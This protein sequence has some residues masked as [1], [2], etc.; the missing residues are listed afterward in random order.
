M[1]TVIPSTRIRL[2]SMNNP[3]FPMLCPLSTRIAGGR[4]FH[5]F[6]LY[7]LATDKALHTPN[8]DNHPPTFYWLAKIVHA[9]WPTLTPQDYRNA[10]LLTTI[11]AMALYTFIG[12]RLAMPLIGNVVYALMPWMINMHLQ[13]GFY[14]NDC[15]AI[16]GGML[17]VYASLLW[18][19]R[20]RLNQAYWLG[21]FGLALAS[22][23][24]TAFLLVGLYA[25]TCLL[26]EFR[27]ARA[28]AWRC[29]AFAVAVGILILLP[30]AYLIQ[31]TG[32]P[33]PETPGQILLMTHHPAG[34]NWSRI[35]IRGWVQEPRMDFPHWLLS[36]LHDFVVQL[37]SFD[38][39]FLPLLLIALTLLR[40]TLQ[41]Q[42][43]TPVSRM[44]RAGL[45]S[46]GITLAIHATFAWGRYLH[47]GWR[48]DSGLRYYFP[49]LALY[50]S[51][52]GSA[53]IGLSRPRK[54]TS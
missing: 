46:T 30:Y 10:A 43:R 16:L 26:L 4:D 17:V 48:L 1:S 2:R 7:D 12:I 50:G 36:F 32:S 38:L 28:I 49:L 29:W 15:A 20:E 54:E 39:T 35:L 40:A 27:A 18:F 8:Y 34:D 19:A 52:C 13:T 21:L 11:A 5:H 33:A 37:D 6:P 44:Q 23:K 22:V 9:A 53:L 47:Y 24:L 51:A 42:T 14:N 25:L 45:I 31:L 41:S 3:I